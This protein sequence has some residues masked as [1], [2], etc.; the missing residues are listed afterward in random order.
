MKDTRRRLITLMHGGSIQ[1]EIRKPIPY[2]TKPGKIL[3]SMTRKK[4]L[5][6]CQEFMVKSKLLHQSAGLIAP[7]E[8]QN[9]SS[10]LS[11]NILLLRDVGNTKDQWDRYCGLRQGGKMSYVKARNTGTSD[12]FVEGSKI[13]GGVS[14]LKSSFSLNGPRHAPKVS[15]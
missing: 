3:S 7:V 5:I 2:Q 14:D 1:K 4:K 8:M 15:N 13:G 11:N 6:P 10:Q 12:K 9:L